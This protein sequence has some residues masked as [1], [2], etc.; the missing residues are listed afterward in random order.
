MPHEMIPGLYLGSIGAA[1]NKDVLK[2]LGITHI[3]VAAYN[4]DPEYPGE[5]NYIKLELKDSHEQNII[6]YFNKCN[7]YIDNAF[8]ENKNNRVLIHCFNGRSRSA[9]IT[10]AYLMYKL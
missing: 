2:K 6:Q 10:M 8:S 5:F 1:S 7:R 4:L 9:T 3:I